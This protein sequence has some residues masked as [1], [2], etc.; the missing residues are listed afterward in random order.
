V[1]LAAGSGTYFLSRD[2]CF[3]GGARR[4][5]GGTLVS[6]LGVETARRFDGTNETAVRDWVRASY[7]TWLTP[8]TGNFLLGMLS[9]SENATIA[10]GLN[11]VIMDH[12]VDAVDRKGSTEL[13]FRSGSTKAIEPDSWIVNCTG[14]MRNAHPYEPY[15]SDSGAVLSIQQRSA[16]FNLMSVMA[17]F[18]SHLLFLDKLRELPLYE[19]DALDL[20]SKSSAVFPYALLS[21]AVYNVRI[22]AD[23]V[24]TKVFLDLGIDFDRWYPWPRQMMRGARF[25]FTHRRQREH[26]RHSLDTVRERFDVRCGPLATEL[27]GA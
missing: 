5:W 6:N 12:L 27:V 24:P 11:D 18:M 10:A 23:S 17:Y 8:D 25:M 26:L 1:N 14:Y 2:R 16:T 22:I 15:A 9:E 4:W 3:P 21:L 20:R 19:L 13:V 7:G